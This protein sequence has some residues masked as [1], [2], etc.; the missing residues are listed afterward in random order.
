MA[1]EAV[2][3]NDSV[4]RDYNLK[5]KVNNGECKAEAVM[6][7]FIYYV[8]FNIYKKL[9]GILGEKQFKQYVELVCGLKP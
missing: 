3:A 5:M 8:L 4:L 1:L 9:V 7:T 2:N 6:K